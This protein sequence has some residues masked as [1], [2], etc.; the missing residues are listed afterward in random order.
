M[1]KVLIIDDDAQ[2]LKTLSKV[3][4]MLNYDVLSAASIEDAWEIILK[5]PPSLI[6]SDFFFKE[7]DV[8][9]LLSKLKKNKYDS[10]IP[11]VVLT[12]STEESV[13]NICSAKGAAALITKP[14]RINELEE[15]IN[16]L[17]CGE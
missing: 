17:N 3:F 6:V 8:C 9:D 1:K 10:G 13:R 16:S 2:L 15:I 4:R 11:V 14:F 5:E 12:G 7:N